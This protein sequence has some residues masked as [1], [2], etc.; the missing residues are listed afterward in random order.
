MYG[1]L[2]QALKDM[3]LTQ[4]GEDVWSRVAAKANVSDDVHFDGMQA[5]DDSV[6]SGLVGA[7]A[8]ETQTALDDV[9]YRFGVHWVGFTSQH[10]YAQLF[11][12]AGPSLRD[13]LLHLDMLHVKVARSYPALVPPSFRF[14]MI[15]T[16]TLR[17]HYI[18][19]RQGLCPMVPGLLQGL[20]QRFSTPVKVT[21]DQCSRKG[22]AH[23]EFVIE[24]SNGSALHESSSG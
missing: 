2:N 24:F 22:A 21:E 18:S 7:L 20:S 17:M 3:I 6:V 15:G 14:S 8:D 1:L 10:G 23:C 19:K 12:I 4:H 5:Y 13:F 11:D 9:L 16:D